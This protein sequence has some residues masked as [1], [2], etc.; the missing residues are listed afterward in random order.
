MFLDKIFGTRNN[1]GLKILD[2]K[3]IWVLNIFGSRKNLGPENYG[4]RKN[5]VGKKFGP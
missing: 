5:L 4:S 3:K 2:H 1:C